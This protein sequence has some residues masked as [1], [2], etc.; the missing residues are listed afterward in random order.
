[1]SM[2]HANATMAQVLKRN[3][4]SLR[5]APLLASADLLLF[6]PHMVGLRLP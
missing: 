6:M 3:F 1:M 2:A 5:V 4:V